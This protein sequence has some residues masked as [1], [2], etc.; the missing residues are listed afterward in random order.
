MMTGTQKKI[1]L[2]VDG[3]ENSLEVVR[4]AA[5]IPAFSRN[6]DGVVQCQQ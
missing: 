2:A 1:L 4:Y 3:S 5:K 6:G